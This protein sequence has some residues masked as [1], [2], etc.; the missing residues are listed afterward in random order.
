MFG[1][2]LIYIA[3][4]LLGS[5]KLV[6]QVNSQDIDLQV[7]SRL[8]VNDLQVKYRVTRIHQS[9]RLL[10]LGGYCTVTALANHNMYLLA[11]YKLASQVQVKYRVIYL[12]FNSSHK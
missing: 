6:S 3:P 12:N 11:S 4:Y 7:K 1:V 5:H 9:P 10:Y 8:L 2:L